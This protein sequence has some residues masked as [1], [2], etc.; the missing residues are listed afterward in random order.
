MPRV[1]FI[2]PDGSATT[3]E[4]KIGHSVM[5]TARDNNVAGVVAECGGAAMCA[6]CHVFVDDPF[7]PMTGPRNDIE[8]EMLDLTATQRRST[9]RL[10]CQIKLTEQMDGLIIHLPETQV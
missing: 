2:H 1:T 7:V 5:E 3:V 4:G 9:S 8:E 6:T 10:S